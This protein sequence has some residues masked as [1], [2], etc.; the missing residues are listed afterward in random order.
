MEKAANA[1]NLLVR[2]L[3]FGRKKPANPPVAAVPPVANSQK[4]SFIPPYP[5][6]CLTCSPYQYL[7]ATYRQPQSLPR[8]MHLLLLHASM[9]ARATEIGRKT[10]TE[11]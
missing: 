8:R 1:G 2:K 4:H 3:S 5:R 7:A 6:F 9:E 11:I 10:T